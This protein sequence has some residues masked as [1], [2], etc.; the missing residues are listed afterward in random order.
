MVNMKNGDGDSVLHILVTN[1]KQLACIQRVVTCGADLI[2]FNKK[3][4]WSNF[5]GVKHSTLDFF[6]KVEGYESSLLFLC[7]QFQL[8]EDNSLSVHIF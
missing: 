4:R 2:S 5:L 7:I 8:L 6:L 3:V 1:S